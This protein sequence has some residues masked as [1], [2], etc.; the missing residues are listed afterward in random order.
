MLPQNPDISIKDNQTLMSQKGKEKTRI[1]YFVK[2]DT[3]IRF[4]D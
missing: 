1:K 3:S 2:Q 4:A